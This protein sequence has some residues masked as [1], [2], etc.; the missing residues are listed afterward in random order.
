MRIDTT[1]TG[2]ARISS[3]V[4]GGKTYTFSAYV[5]TGDSPVYLKIGSAVSKNLAA[6]SGWTRLQVSYK[7][8][9][10]QSSLTLQ[11]VN[12]GA[13]TTYVDAVQL[14]QAHTASRYN[15]VENGDFRTTDSW[16]TGA[17]T[18]TTST[19]SGAPQL[20]NNAFKISGTYDGNYRAYQTIKVKGDEGDC[21]VLAGWAK[22][23]AVPYTNFSTTQYNPSSQ[24]NHGGRA[25]CLQIKFEYADGTSSDDYSVSFNPAV[26][27]WQYVAAPMVAPHDY[28][29][30]KVY[31][32]YVNG[33]NAIWFDG[34][35]LYKERFGSFYAYNAN[36]TVKEVQDINGG[37][38][39]YTHN[40]KSDLTKVESPDGTETNYVYD[41]Y[42]NVTR[43]TT[44]A[45]WSMNMNTMPLAT[46]LLCPS[47]ATAVP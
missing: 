13:G 33:A 20:S 28:T 22:G 45:V 12:T 1:S 47:P 21:F 9:S 14:E 8:S 19:D 26:E 43:M 40:I 16:Y 3:A 36:G 42:H 17:G 30:I 39:N 27:N 25:F 24:Y 32:S 37:V 10:S 15:L 46:I 6:G 34:I 29:A 31:T 23:N 35:Q 2:Y 11:I 4:E 44:D 7:P 41:N 38:T 18:V 5:K